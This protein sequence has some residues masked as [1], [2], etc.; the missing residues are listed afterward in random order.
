M[1]AIKENTLHP[2]LK[3]EVPSFDMVTSYKDY[4][5][6]LSIDRAVMFLHPF[7]PSITPMQYLVCKIRSELRK[8]HETV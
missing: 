3:S 8:K 5:Y 4:L 1:A 7:Q 2:A 6:E